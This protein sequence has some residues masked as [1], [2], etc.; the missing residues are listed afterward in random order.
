[1]KKK[2]VDKL[3]VIQGKYFIKIML[4]NMTKNMQIISTNLLK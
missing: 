1:M 4:S 2:N 3:K